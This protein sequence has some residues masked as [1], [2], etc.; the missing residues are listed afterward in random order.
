MFTGFSPTEK[1][2][3]IPVKLKDA[4]FFTNPIAKDLTLPNN[5][6]D[7]LDG[8]SYSDI[9]GDIVT[10]STGITDFTDYWNLGTSDSSIITYQN[11]GG[12][13]AI[14]SASGAPVK[15]MTLDLKFE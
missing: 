10:T 8:N 2:R 6:R 7:D 9:C 1:L 14:S 12:N 15:S 4:A 11:Q 5:L 3:T 13:W